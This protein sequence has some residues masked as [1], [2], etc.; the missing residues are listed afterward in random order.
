MSELSTAHMLSYPAPHP[1]TL[2][3]WYLGYSV[4]VRN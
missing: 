2:F 4:L 3:V 1:G